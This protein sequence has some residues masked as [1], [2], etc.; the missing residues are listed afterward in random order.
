M[1][2]LSRR[3]FIEGTTA[4][5][6]VTIASPALAS[7]QVGAPPPPSVPIPIINVNVPVD[8]PAMVV[9]KAPPPP[10][11]VMTV[12]ATQAKTVRQPDCG[13]DYYPAQALRLNQQGSVVV[14]IC[15][16]ANNKIDGPIELVTSSGFPSLDEAAGKCLS[17]GSY[18]A[19]TI[20]GKPA[21]TC[22][23]MKVT[24]K[25]LER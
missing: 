4:A 6:A 21:R 7:A 13:E 24:F 5:I 15:V 12:A 17:A 9:S 16:G 3:D 2:D 14:K 23:D 22:K 8:V 19:G 11:A 25:P 18:K 10:K 1:A 20:E